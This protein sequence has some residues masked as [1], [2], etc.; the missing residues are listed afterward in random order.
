[1]SLSPEQLFIKYP[2]IALVEAKNENIMG[3]LGQCLAEMI[4]ARIFNK[5]EVLGL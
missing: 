3:G 5:A 4:A 1:M 2:I